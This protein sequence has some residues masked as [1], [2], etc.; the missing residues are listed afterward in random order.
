MA[1]FVVAAVAAIYKVTA[2][3]DHHSIFE[4]E[5]AAFDEGLDYFLCS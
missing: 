2:S 4:V 1:A 5:V 3:Q